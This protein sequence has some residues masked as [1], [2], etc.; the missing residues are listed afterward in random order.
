MAHVVTRN[1]V[2]QLMRHA[3][4]FHLLDDEG[5]NVGIWSPVDG[6][7]LAKSRMGDW[8]TLKAACER[9]WPLP[10]PKTIRVRIAV[11]AGNLAPWDVEVHVVESRGDDHARQGAA[12]Q[13]RVARYA[14]HQD[15]HAPM[16]T[17]I[18]EA[19]VPLPESVTVEG[20]VVG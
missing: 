2:V 20:E 11:A 7:G 16:A 17:H 9:S 13:L 15:P 6:L 8:E 12:A 19:T 18:I 3:K 10:Q 5:S 14:R 4:G 1:G